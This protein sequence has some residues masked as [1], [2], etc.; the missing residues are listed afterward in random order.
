MQAVSQALAGYQ[1]K[2]AQAELAVSQDR[3]AHQVLAG[4]QVFQGRAL[5]ASQAFQATQALGQADF[6]GLAGT[7]GTQDNRVWL[8]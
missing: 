7:A 1:D 6:R 3:M 8:G 2:T 5:A 4:S